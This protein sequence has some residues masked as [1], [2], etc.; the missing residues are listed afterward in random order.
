MYAMNIRKTVSFTIL[1][2]V[3]LLA[4]SC[5]GNNDDD[6]VYTDDT[7]ITSFSLGTLNRVFH[8]T[9]STG[10]DSTYTKTLDCS[11][12]KFYIDQATAT[13]YNPDSLP[14]G[15]DASKALVTVGT[16]NSGVATLKSLTSDSLSYISSSDSLDFS[17]PRTVRVYSNSGLAYR[18]YTVHVN[19]HQEVADSFSWKQ[20]ATV[21]LFKRMTGME[22][23]SLNGQLTVFGAVDGTTVAV[24]STDGGVTWRQLTFNFNHTLSA[25]AYKGVIV[26]DGYVYLVDGTQVLRSKDASDWETVASG[27]SLKMLVA[28]SRTRFYAY[29]NASRLVA[30]TDGCQ[31]WTLCTLDDELSLLPTDNINAVCTALR[32][33]TGADRVLL[34]GN[35][36]AAEYAS[37]ASAVV[38]GKI[39]ET[40]GG[41][42][43]Q[44]WAYY[45]VSG[46]NRFYAPRLSG[47]QATTYDD[48]VAL[49]G[50]KTLGGKSREA[51]DSVY[52]SRDGGVTWIGDTTIYVPTA[53]TEAMTATGTEP[54]FGFTSDSDNFLWLVS[55]ADGSVW[56]GRINRL[57]WRKEQTSF[58]E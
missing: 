41:A 47:L 15:T 28:A 14:V 56:K 34:I 3:A 18:D 33:N 45:T 36:N 32:T 44:P 30:S 12:Y 39:D 24:A 35:R 38:W 25:D 26:H 16:K 20:T 1:L 51:F 6:Y 21:E 50:G 55:G 7:A 13:V 10:K 46:D 8:V 57:G 52:V 17:K 27:L 37:D 5:L 9:D 4:A 49:V 43:Q 53:F 54:V 2:S 29:D 31:T 22:A 11:G 42:E 23:V 48:G 58:T 40:D 19:V